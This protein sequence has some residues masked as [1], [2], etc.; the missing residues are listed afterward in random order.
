MKMFS[1]IFLGFAL[2]FMCVFT[3]IGYAALNDELIVE[4]DANAAPPNAIFITEIKNVTTHNATINEG[5]TNITYPSTKF[6]TDITFNGN[7][8]YVKLDLV[9]LNGTEIN[10]YFDTVFE[11][12]QI[13]GLPDQFVYTNVKSQSSVAQGTVM[14][15]GDIRTFTVTLTFTGSGNQTR[16]MLHE[17]DFVLDSNDLT[18][19]VSKDVT[20]V[21]ADIL[22]NKLESDVTYTYNNRNYTV[23]K[24]ATYT[25]LREKMEWSL[26][27]NYVG[28]LDGADGDDK[29][30]VNALFG[31]TLK[32]SVGDTEVPVTVMA[33]EKN[34][35]GSSEKEMVLY[36]TADDLTASSTYVPVYAVVFTK[37]TSGQWVQIG[38][39]FAGEART[40]DYSGW[41]GSGSFNTERWRSTQTYK[42]AAVGSDINTVISKY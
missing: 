9:V 38:E 8:S 3:S 34:V 14:A 28:N 39:I 17:L 27:G 22:N 4:G 12:D 33:K 31:D 19:A 25:A 30:L 15:P 6:L 13:E 21:F 42:G 23:S 10:Q 24:D 16:R 7:N 37:D 26:S 20:D 32:F 29:A 1:K 36:I 41:A 5:P 11:Y 40:N 2:S 35:Y 18:Q